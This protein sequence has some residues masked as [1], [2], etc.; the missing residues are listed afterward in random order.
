M[1]VY[2]RLAAIAAIALA[3]R[4]QQ[5][6][7]AQ[8]ASIG[9]E[10]G[11]GI[12]QQRCMGCHGNA[13]AAEKAPDPSTLRQLPPERIYDAL[14]SGA[15]KTIGQTLTDEQRRRVAESVSGRLLGSAAAGNAIDMPNHCPSNPPLADPS[16]GPAWNSWGADIR[17][18]RF[19]TAQ[20]AGL[21]ADEVPR[22]KLKWAFGYPGGVSA[23]G[24]PTVVAGCVFTGTDTGFIYSL[25]AGTGCVYWS[26]QTKAGVRNAMTV[27]PV[28]G[29]GATKFAVYFGDLKANVYAL[30]AQNGDMLWVNHVEEHFTA[31]ITAAPV[32][33][34]GRLYVPVSSWEEFSA[35][36]PD[37]PCCTFRGSVLEL[38]SNTGRQIWKTYVIPQEPKPV[39]KNSNGT[40]LWA[41][42]GASVWNSP[43]VDLRRHAIYFGTGDSETEPAATT[44]D[45]IMALDMNTGKMLWVYQAEENDSY[46]VGCV[47]EN[48]TENCPAVEGPDYDIG[49]SP[50][51]RTLPGGKRV[52]VA[53]MKNGEVFAL[54]PD[55]KGAKLWRGQRRGP[56]FAAAS[57][58]A[59]RQTSITHTSGLSG[60]G[61]AAVPARHRRA[62]LV[63]AV[64]DRTLTIASGTPQLPLPSQAWFSRRAETESC[65][66]SPQLTGMACGNMT[67]PGPLI[68]SITFRRR[69]VRFAP[70]VSRW[71]AEC[72]LQDRDTGSAEPT[73]RETFCWPSRFQ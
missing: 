32:F 23:F 25:D 24:Q 65:T 20:A 59:A 16:A 71:R 58:G 9:T 47:G 44:S 51:L 26:F 45:A 6:P 36:T 62:P 57:S 67:L 3:A 7:A 35:R 22:L 34:E 19:Q 15:M 12:F 17:N 21:T 60:G 40:Q 8:P 54:D 61:A 73:S 37:Y 53:A 27:A 38:D 33:Y 69:V 52:V 31:R 68:R 43:T 50:I 48:R 70:P 14:T 64:G 11:F 56:A 2:L 18:T 1:R 72:S 49:N 5:Q 13:N 39:K 42:G 55:K 29:H 4:A 10:A 41:P 66:R 46:L 30:D 28:K 63:R